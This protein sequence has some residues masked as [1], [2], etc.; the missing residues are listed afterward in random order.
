[1]NISKFHGHIGSLDHIG[2]SPSEVLYDLQYE[3]ARALQLPPHRP[4][5]A[6]FTGV[7]DMASDMDSDM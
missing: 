3:L 4:G 6:G 5:V 7:M 1:M 2:S